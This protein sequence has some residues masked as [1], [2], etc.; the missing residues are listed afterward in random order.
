MRHDWLRDLV[1]LIDAGSVNAAAT[2]RNIS[3]SAFSRR[4]Q[5]LEAAL[6][7][8]LI[9]RHSKPSLPSKTLQAHADEIR[10]LLIQQER[11]FKQLQSENQTG[12]SLIV[13]VSQHAIT[14]AQGH[15]IV[16]KVSES[17]KTLVRLRSANLDDCETM[18][19]TGQAD[20]ALTYRSNRLTGNTE[21]A[22]IDSVAIAEDTL[23][24]VFSSADVNKLMWRFHNG[25]LNI[26]G[27]PSDV[28]F[29]IE[30]THQVL[31]TLE[32]KCRLSLTVETALSP[33]ALELA[34]AS[35]GVAWVP[36]ALAEN[37]L[38]DGS[39]VDLRAEFGS[40]DL[41]VVAHRLYS[42]GSIITNPTWWRLLALSPKQQ[43]LQPQ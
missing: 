25:E 4:I 26:I 21:H 2:A 34:A 35:V 14:T 37:K 23:I 6:N 24:P 16:K 38:L 32:D 17:G 13:I 15:K 28:F 29:G 43:K 7:L 41:K 33:A 9:E 39:I 3:Q 19:L 27:Y 18:L 11:L 31:P 10:Q 1:A 5:S 12:S 22:L 8:T 36:Y 42:A 40:I 20:F 30:L